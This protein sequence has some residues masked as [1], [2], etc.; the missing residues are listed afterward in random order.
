M[1]DIIKAN[2]NGFVV[3]SIQYRVSLHV[4]LRV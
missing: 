3:V 4:S 1:T 2:D